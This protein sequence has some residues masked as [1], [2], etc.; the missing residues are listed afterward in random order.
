M[1]S[2]LY[3]PPQSMLEARSKFSLHSFL[4]SDAFS[5]WVIIIVVW[6]VNLCGLNIRPGRVYSDRL[7][8]SIGILMR[9][10]SRE[11]LW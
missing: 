6:G 2:D 3:C 10:E 4:K 11:A 5:K 7:S 8:K 1:I 9:D